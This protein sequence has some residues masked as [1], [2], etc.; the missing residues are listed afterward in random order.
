MKKLTLTI[1]L[2]TSTFAFA[3]GSHETPTPTLPNPAIQSTSVGVGVNVDSRASAGAVAVSGDSSAKSGSFSNGGS[4][5][6]GSVSVN[7][8]KYTNQAPPVFMT[9]APSFSQRNCQAVGS[10]T[11]SGPFGGLGAAFGL[12][13]DT[14]DAENL[15]DIIEAWVRDTNDQKLW[16]VECEMLVSANDNLA[17]AFEKAHYSCHD[18]YVKREAAANTRAKMAALNR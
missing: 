17:D 6:N 10:V 14:C 12:N 5:Q 11:A 2:L 8:T 18:A 7:G 1:L 9:S 15:S 4:A 16:E 3:G 13:S